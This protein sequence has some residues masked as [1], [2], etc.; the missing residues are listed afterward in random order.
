MYGNLAAITGMTKTSGGKKNLQVPG[1]QTFYYQHQGSNPLNQQNIKQGIKK[2]LKNKVSS[3]TSRMQS[4]ND[5][6]M[7]G[8]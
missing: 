6:K 8:G 5:S 7:A 1:N 3:N 4:R 2:I